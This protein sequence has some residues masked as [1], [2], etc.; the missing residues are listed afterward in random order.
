MADYEIVDVTK[1]QKAEGVKDGDTLLL[2]RQQGDGTS[3]CMR[4]D[5]AQFKG[6]DAYDVAKAN[7]FS[8]TREE[9]AQQVARIN[10][11]SAAID[12]ANDTANHPVKI[13][14][15]NYVYEWNKA[16]KAYQK[17]GILVKGDKGERGATGAQGEQGPQGA[18]GETGAR[19]ATGPQGA[20]GA[21][22]PQGERG[23][24][25]KSP[26]I[27]NASWWIWD[28]ASGAYKDSGMSV[29]SQYT[30]TKG[31]VEGVLTGDVSS[32]THSQYALTSAI[33]T[34]VSDLTNDSG[35]LT[36]HQSLDGYVNEVQPDGTQSGNGIAN[37]TKEGK[38]LKVTKSTFLTEHQSL[39][40]YAKQAWV[41]QNA[42]TQEWV[43]SQ[44]YLTANDLHE[45]IKI[46]L[47]STK[48]T[49]DAALKNAVITIKDGNTVLSTHTWTGNAISKT[50]ASGLK[51][52]ISVS[53]VTGYKTPE[54]QS[55][56]TSIG[57][58]REVKMEYKQLILGVYI[59]ET[60]G[61]M[62]EPTIWN[63]D[64]NSTVL[65]VYVGGEN[66]SLVLAPEGT[67][68]SWSR[69][70]TSIPGVR[71]EDSGDAPTDDIDGIGNTEKIIKTLVNENA[72]AAK[73]C[74]QYTFKN[75][76]KGYFFALGEALVVYNNL[77][78]VKQAYSALGNT[79]VYEAL[80]SGILTSNQQGSSK[81]WA[82]GIVTSKALVMKN[83][84]LLVIPVY[85]Y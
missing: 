33:P 10:E 74:N 24:N 16:T 38:V 36:T 77:E 46:T 57:N 54:P 30:L 67:Q 40:D 66:C 78:K 2:I 68:R 32:H 27:K 18:K 47:T 73:Y 69:D 81:A 72:N 42:A 29:S 59:L 20:T 80:S 85:K 26:I 75:G 45:T 84:Y 15:D 4:T 11:V 43:K 51:I 14:A 5:G 25:G 79:T 62:T 23:E 6:T 12:N 65:G 7:G 64:N 13:G 34:K 9:W 61:T 8:G 3:I 83:D 1:L 19:G 35:F 76:K 58:T 44:K 52:T 49:S 53:D 50:V 22:G 63:K 71:N 21:Q 82:V 55:F 56:T 41:R 70:I 60:D 17:T 37:I 28:E 39:A 48:S 31:A